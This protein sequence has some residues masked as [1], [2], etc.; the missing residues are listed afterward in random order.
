VTVGHDDMRMEDVSMA[1]VSIE[2]IIAEYKVCIL[3]F[4]LM[5]SSFARKL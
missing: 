5:Y 3:I 2:N 1:D 4:S